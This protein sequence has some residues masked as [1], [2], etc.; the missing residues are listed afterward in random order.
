[1]LTHREICATEFGGKVPF[2]RDLRDATQGSSMG[3]QKPRV[4]REEMEKGGI[5]S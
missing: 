4:G 2:L 1:M 3:T 5:N